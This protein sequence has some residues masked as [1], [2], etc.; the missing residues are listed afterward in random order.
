[1]N[2]YGIRDSQTFTEMYHKATKNGDFVQV[3]TVATAVKKRFCL[4]FYDTIY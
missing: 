3:D 1:M 2:Q 4:N